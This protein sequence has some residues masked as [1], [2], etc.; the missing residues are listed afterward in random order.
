[1]D[2]VLDV[3]ERVDLA[4][5]DHFAGA[6]DADVLVADDFAFGDVAAGDDDALRGAEGSSDFG[7]AELGVFEDG[8]QAAL[9]GALDVIGQLVDYI[10]GQNLNVFLFGSLLG[11]LVGADVETDDYGFGGGGEDDV[12]FADVAY[13]GVE[14]PQLYFGLVELV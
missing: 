4:G 8:R 9:H 2:I 10:E 3:L 5:E 11:G 12:G 13:A 6:A 7:F 1:S 14:N